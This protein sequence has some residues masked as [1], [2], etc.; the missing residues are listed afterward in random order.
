MF[1]LRL[2]GGASLARDDGS[3]VAGRAGQRHRLALLALLA[4][5]PGRA[6]SRDKLVG[7]LWPESDSERARN[8][9]KVSV[10]VLRQALGEEALVSGADDLRLSREVVTADVDEFERAIGEG[11]PASAVAVY[12]GPLL[13]GFFLPDAP[14]FE[15]WLDAERE[16]LAR[17]YA[18][19]LEELAEGAESRG[20]FEGAAEWW[21]RR[22][23]HDPYDSRVAMS[24]MRALDASG[25][26]AGALQH[27]S[28]HERLLQQELGLQTPSPV[29]RF[30]DELR[31]SPHQ[32]PA[33]A[34]VAVHEPAAEAVLPQ[35]PAAGPSPSGELER[36]SAA[37]AADSQVPS[38]PASASPPARVRRVGRWW[39]GALALIGVLVVAGLAWKMSPGAQPQ[40][41]GSVA[42]LPFVNISPDRDLEYFSDGVTEEIITHLSAFPTLKVISR[43]SAMR[44]KGSTKS[45]REIATELRV[46]HVLEGS[47]RRE[48]DTVRI[49][50]QLI[51]AGTD[52]HLWSQRYD[53]RLVDVFA[54]Q[55][56][57]AREV[58]RALELK[59]VDRDHVPARR[60]TAD[61]EAYE[62]YLRG[63]HVW[64]TRTPEAH[65]RAIAYFQRAVERDSGYADAYAGMADVYLTGFQLNVAGFS[66]SEADAYARLRW[67]AERA[68]ALDDV[69]AEAHTSLG[70][71]HWWR[72]DW[73]AAE[74]ELR[75]AIELNPGYATAR[76]WYSLLLGGFGRFDEA[77]RE[78]RRAWE[79]DPFAL[80]PSS[81]HG[82]ALILARRYDEAIEQY[83]RTLELD[84]GWSMSHVGMGI[85]FDQ[86]GMHAEAV[87]AL[88]RAVELRPER[89]EHR[90]KLAY[91]LARAGSADEAR[92]LLREVESE[93][94]QVVAVRAAFA[95]GHA[96][97]ALGEKD[98]AFTWLERTDWRWPQ[99]ANLYDPALD[100]VRDD[101]RFRRLVE[102]VARERGI[103]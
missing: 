98:R 3:P 10:Y 73:V 92:Q 68:V 66:E 67:A 55:E 100:P 28:I 17:T 76:T 38:P 7:L 61:P 48:G 52:H 47:V 19:A 50:A 84:D 62:L 11:D 5:A 35:T 81:N 101:P 24:L 49:T 29:A 71:A 90:A 25:N 57:I 53:R 87:R 82:W 40:P 26:R 9:L 58:G 91:V 77:V 72:G 45:L 46:A 1:R 43:T 85:A 6:L 96:Y 56:D 31:A 32:A 78:S 12:G 34:A 54:V 99:R 59:L 70:I 75:R 80:V 64:Q 79:L 94:A 37:V 83:R 103:R 51:D 18:R 86:K 21:R 39:A 69:S 27:A 23:M 14:E 97:L 60:G 44:Y 41:E 65:Q 33:A 88:R 20:D 2:L 36:A 74:R 15:R 13:D 22:A 93:P 30:A 42:V 102:R 95:L 16:R 63:R 4:T 8:L 89:P